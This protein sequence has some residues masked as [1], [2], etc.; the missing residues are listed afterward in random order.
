[1]I[2]INGSAST[3]AAVTQGTVA[4]KTINNFSSGAG[5]QFQGGNAAQGPGVT[6]GV[7]DGDNVGGGDRTSSASPATSSATASVT[8]GIRYQ[9]HPRRRQRD[10]SGQFLDHQQRHSLGADPAF[11]GHRHCG[12][13]RQQADVDFFIDNNFIDASDNIFNSS[14]MAVG[15]PGGRGDQTPDGTIRAE[16]TNNNINGMEGNGILAGV[17]NSS[18]PGLSRSSGNTVG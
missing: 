13:R 10:R 9:R 11:R 8:G 14:G 3:G 6:L 5:I 17:T 2:D 12:V 18:T 15:K 1:M 4:N 7:P 16:I